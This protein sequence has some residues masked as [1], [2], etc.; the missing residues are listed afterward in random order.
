MAKKIVSK[1]QEDKTIKGDEEVPS[2]KEKKATKTPEQMN[3]AEFR[4]AV[5]DSLKT[6]CETELESGK[7]LKAFIEKWELQQKAGKF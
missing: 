7:R 1:N 2:E 3:D 4:K 5:M 6:L